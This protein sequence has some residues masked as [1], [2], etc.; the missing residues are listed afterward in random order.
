VEACAAVRVYA[1][2]G[3]ES[4]RER[5]R[6]KEGENAGRSAYRAGFRP[7]AKKSQQMLRS[8]VAVGEARKSRS[9]AALVYGEKQE[10]RAMDRLSRWEKSSAAIV[11][12]AS[13]ANIEPT[14]FPRTC[15]AVATT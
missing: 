1:R 10:K 4:E 14:R 15:N 5:E 9:F 7:E 13:Y 6:E 11:E 12:R 8:H 3:R 2:T